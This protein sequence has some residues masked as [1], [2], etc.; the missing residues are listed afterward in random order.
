MAQDEISPSRKQAIDS[1]ALE[2]VRDLSKY[3]SIVGNKDT[4]WSEANRVIERTQELFA[5]GALMGVSTLG[6]EEI[7]YY[8]IRE[9]LERLMALNYDKVNIQWYNIQYIS[10]LERQPDGRYVGVITIYQRFEGTTKEGLRYVDVTKK[11]VTV[12]VERKT[13][14]ISGRIIGFWDVL[15]GDIRVSETKPG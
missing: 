10:D 14:Q 7:N 3:I 8:G 4:P 1:L 9:Y 13:T 5:D 2:K 6:R 11:D 12:Y 15:L